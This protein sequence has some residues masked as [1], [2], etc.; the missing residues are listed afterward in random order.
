MTRILI[1]VAT[2]AAAAA[3]CASTLGCG[4]I[5]NVSNAVDNLTEVA[6][7][8]EKLTASANLTYTA[9][10]KLLDGTGEA[11]VIQQPP[12]A[13]FIGKDGRFILTT[14]SL[15]ICSGTGA[16]TTCQRTPNTNGSMPSADQAA[17]MTAVAGAG[18]ISTPM[19]VALMGAAS[20]VPSVNIT[21]STQD[22]A[23]LASTCLR[24]TGISSAQQAGQGNVDMQEATVCVADNGVLTKF[25]GVGTDGSHIG[26]QLASYSTDVDPKSFAPP[27]G[28]KITDVDQL[29]A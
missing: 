4:V 8:S 19:A 17:Y 23:G 16:K 12:Q 28:A 1:R 25:A 26:V 3:L 18:F 27:K 22:I 13:A 14:D 9:G 11:T 10:Y 6:D 5:A 20:I 7:L 15:L 2:L 21:K 29:T 24:A